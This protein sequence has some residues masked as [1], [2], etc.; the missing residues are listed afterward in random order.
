[1]ASKSTKTAENGYDIQ[2][3]VSIGHVPAREY[4]IMD[5]LIPIL[6]PLSYL[7]TVLLRRPRNREIAIF[8][9]EKNI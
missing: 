8:L 5:R 7:W 1:M 6:T 9:G 4:I 2:M 3:M